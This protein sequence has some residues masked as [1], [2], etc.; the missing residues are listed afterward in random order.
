M[1]V[2][3]TDLEGVL[4]FEPTIHRD[5]RGYFMESW[6]RERYAA[7]GLDISFVQDNVSFSKNAV[8]RGLHFQV[9]PRPQGKLV[10]VLS[11]EVF[12]VAVDL[13]SGAPTFGRWVGRYLSEENRRQ[14][15]V[16]VGFAH[17]FVVTSQ[18]A[19]VSY[20]CTEVYSPGHERSLAWDDPEVGIEWP[21]SEPLLSPKD[22]AAPRLH[23]LALAPVRER[24]ANAAM[25]RILLTG[26]SGRLGRELRTLLPG[27]NAPPSRELDI[28]R[29]D[30]IRRI[31][32]D[33]RP[34]ILVH[35]AA[36]TDVACAEVRRDECWR[37]NVEGTRTLVRALTDRGIFLVHISTD[38]VFEGNQG[39]YQED[40]SVGPVR[41]YYSLSKL[42]AEEV[43]RAAAEHLVIRTSFRPREWPYPTAF[44]DVY[45]SQDYVDVIAPK[46]AL[47]VQHCRAIPHRVLHIAT[48]RK[49]VFDLA[50]RRRP[51][52]QPASKRAAGVE[53][54]D[55]CS[56]DT[57]RWREL[58]ANLFRFRPA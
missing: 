19:L 47:A 27:T 20:K 32:D 30:M 37:V 40:D 22:Q 5:K 3:E 49:S 45:T 4:V 46:I 11:G 1:K 43:A 15:Y 38:Y 25:P 29:P 34:E 54:P 7:A 41:N 35:A 58:E 42:V 44:T 6:N 51:D 57:S 23:E 28:T 2:T 56:L 16:P 21:V 36:F 24:M 53:L 17:G 9:P 39:G 33:F 55:D 31:L 13:R 10:S 12:D 50:R 52:V 18:T 48:E 14:L 8:L 26:G